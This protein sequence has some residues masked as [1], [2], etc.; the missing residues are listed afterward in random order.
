ML[1]IPYF[2]SIENLEIRLIIQGEGELNIL[3]N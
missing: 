2:I 3:N 1:L